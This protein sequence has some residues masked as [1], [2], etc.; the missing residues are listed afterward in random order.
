MPFFLSPS[1][2]KPKAALEAQE[3]VQSKSPMRRISGKLV[4]KVKRQLWRLDEALHHVTHTQHDPNAEA[5]E[6]RAVRARTQSLPASAQLFRAGVPSSPRSSRSGST[7]DYKHARARSSFD[8]ESCSS[9]GD[10]HAI[11]AVYVTPA[12]VVAPISAE[13]LPEEC[14][15]LEGSAT[16]ESPC[17][18]PKTSSPPPP[19][20]VE[21]PEPEL[22]VLID[23]SAP[24]PASEEQCAPAAA[25]VTVSS[26][27]TASLSPSLISTAA[28]RSQSSPPNHCHADAP[29]LPSDESEREDVPEP[30]PEESESLEGPLAGESPCVETIISSPPAVEAEPALIDASAPRPLAEEQ[31]ASAFAVSSD[32]T[33]SSLP[34][35]NFADVEQS[36][37]SPPNPS[38]DALPPPSDE[39]EREVA[40]APHAYVLARVVPTPIS[41]TPILPNMRHP[42]ST[43][44]LTW[45]MCRNFMYDTCSTSPGH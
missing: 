38:V 18:E 23:V 7:W 45:W 3:G 29:P 31:C 16:G 33:A 37:S 13:I 14:Q 34:S 17:A 43:N 6:R 41:F 2:S 15:S 42:F 12:A 28:E 1:K 9:D 8:R 36:Q 32:H 20:E 27:H 5:A 21:A 26:D 44:L 11:Q 4:K 25:V 24:R 22:P 10:R 40:P 39:S 30:R 35:L 19:V